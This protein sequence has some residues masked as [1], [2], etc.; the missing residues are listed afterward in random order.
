MS[1]ELEELFKNV[2]IGKI[3]D[4]WKK[5]SYPS[6]KPLG[7]YIQDFIG[8][9]DFLQVKKIEYS[10]NGCTSQFVSWLLTYI[11]LIICRSG[12]MREP[13]V[14]FGCLDSFSLR[15]FSRAPNRISPGNIK[16]QLTC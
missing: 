6:L 16:Y 2:L 14:L 11:N 1:F 5:H 3:P 8:R 13:Q 4:L 12:T 9:L 7:S 15:L 10:T